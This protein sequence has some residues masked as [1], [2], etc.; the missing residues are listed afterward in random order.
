MFALPQDRNILLAQTTIT[1]GESAISSGPGADTI[2]ILIRET[3]V[4][5]CY[6]FRS[7]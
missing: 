1:F 4:A 5:E 3:D 2:R 6:G 7:S